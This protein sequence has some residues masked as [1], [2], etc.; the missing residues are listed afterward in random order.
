MNQQHFN[1]VFNGLTERRR[2]VLLKLLA[3]E[4]DEAIAKSLHIQKSTVRKHRE[5][6]CKLFGLNNEFPDERRSKLPELIALFAKYKP[7]LLNQ[8]TSE[9]SQTENFSQDKTTFEDPNFVGREEAI[10]PVNSQE[11][12]FAEVMRIEA[13]IKQYE[14]KP[15]SSANL[16]HYPPTLKNWQGRDEEIHQITSWLADNHINIIGIQGLSGIGKSC[17][18]AKVYESQLFEAR[19][20][21]DVREGTDFSVFAK[22]A[23]TELAGKSLE[24]LVTLREPNQLIFALLDILRQRPCLLVFDNL[25]TLLDKERNF[26][27]IYK[28][29]FNRWIEHGT[30]S[31]ILLTTQIQPELMEGHG[32]WLSLSGLKATEGAKLLSDLGIVGSEEELQDFSRYLD[33]HPM[34]LR[35]VASK[36]KPGTHILKSKKL[37]FTELDLLLNKVHMTY[38]DQ[39]RFRFIWILEPHFEDLTPKLK[40]FF[41]N[42]SIFRNEFDLYTASEALIE[43][44]ELT[45]IW[46]SLKND[47]SVELKPSDNQNIE[48]PANAWETQQALD[49]LI[50]RSLLDVLPERHKYKLHP[51]VVQYAKQKTSNEQE[52]FYKKAFARKLM[53]YYLSITPTLD[54]WRTLE[55]AMPFIEIFYLSCEVGA[56][57]H[58]YEILVVYIDQYLYLRGDNILLSEMYE[59]LLQIFDKSHLGIKKMAVLLNKLGSA[60]FYSGRPQE[61]IK[62]SL[63]ALE[64]ARELGDCQTETDALCSLGNAYERLD[65]YEEALQWHEQHLAIASKISNQSWEAVSLHNISNIYLRQNN[66][67]KAIE[68]ANKSLRICQEISNLELEATALASLGNIYLFIKEH[69]QAIDYYNNSLEMLEKVGTQFINNVGNYCFKG[70]ILNNIA[71]TYNQIGQYEQAIQFFNKGLEVGQDIG[72]SSIVYFALEGLGEALIAQASLLNNLAFKF[73]HTLLNLYNQAIDFY[74]KALAIAEDISNLNLKASARQGLHITFCNL[75]HAYRALGEYKQ[76]NDY[77]QKAIEIIESKTV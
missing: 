55:H 58:A 7:E 40:R 70:A 25:E 76:A 9:L 27:E 10:A 4:T 15:N 41:L 64:I 1:A 77:Y 48:E 72:D 12:F 60:Y 61:A 19:F 65:K 30:T 29:F 33:G 57:C 5:E 66:S 8:N 35:L 22:K 11:F 71:S 32:H 37:G 24:E 69:Q 63:Q 74:E 54:S 36:L 20:W 67:E 23:L 53:I 18:A 73:K 43:T 75:S 3:N 49:D 59:D 6:I 42:L 2:E 45:S 34:M 68:Y 46:E 38:R 51:F 31:K 39:E 14:Q 26:Q 16:I 62:T 52:A 50:S 44:E 17:L 21:A 47:I 28:Y 13:R 56:F